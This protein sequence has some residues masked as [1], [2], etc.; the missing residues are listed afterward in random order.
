MKAGGK[1]KVISSGKRCEKKK[2]I[3][4]KDWKKEGSRIG[5]EFGACGGVV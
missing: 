5:M 3:E 2:K 1:T 4:E